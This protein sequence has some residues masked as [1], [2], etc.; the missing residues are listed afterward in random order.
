MMVVLVYI[1]LRRSEYKMETYWQIEVVCDS[2]GGNRFDRQFKDTMN[3]DA[4][5]VIC[6]QCGKTYSSNDIWGYK[7]LNYIFVCKRLGE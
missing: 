1:N 7:N 5:N 4:K 6:L 3:E 2:C